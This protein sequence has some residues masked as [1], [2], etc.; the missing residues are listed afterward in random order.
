MQTSFGRT[1]W[2][3]LAVG[4]VAA[5]VAGADA[6]QLDTAVNGTAHEALFAVASHNDSVIAVGAGGAILASVDKGSTWKAVMPAPTPLSLLG[7]AIA[8]GSA[9]TVGQQGTVLRLDEQGHWQK[10]DSGTDARLFSV[11]VNESG[12]AIAVGSFGAIIKS[13]DG[14]STWSSVAPDWTG[15]TQDGAQP[16]LYGVAIDAAGTFTVVG[17][18]GLILRST[19]DGAHWTQVHKGDASLFAVDLHDPAASFAVGQSGVIL[20]TTD[21]GKSWTDLTSG[22][23]AS[24]L[25]I[26]ALGGGRVVVTGIREMLLSADGGQSWK[27]ISNPDIATSWYQGVESSSDGGAWIVGHSGRILRLGS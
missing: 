27:P 15:Y 24:L 6:A 20:R 17:E 9:L 21:G 10:V 2:R 3:A 12:R 8:P 13:D 4:L 5:S 16:H 14:G 11:A 18:F 22:S 19:D 25:G 7:I 26:R 23:E 1:L